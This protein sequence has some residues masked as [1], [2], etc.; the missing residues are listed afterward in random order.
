M[1]LRRQESCSGYPR[2][3]YLGRVQR[4]ILVSRAGTF[5]VVLLGKRIWQCHLSDEAVRSVFS[6]E[7]RR[8]FAASLNSIRQCIAL[9]ADGNAVWSICHP[10][11]P[12]L[13]VAESLQSTDAIKVWKNEFPKDKCPVHLLVADNTLG[14]FC[15][16]GTNE[17]ALVIRYLND[18]FSADIAFRE[19]TVSLPDS[20]SPSG[21]DVRARGST[22]HAIWR[23]SWY[24][25][26][27]ANLSTRH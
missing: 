20:S 24:S 13:R 5:W 15:N 25:L 17:S 21:W 6:E 7:M 2:F 10:E 1:P 4:S 14:F 26:D 3:P 27:V 11:W 9:N 18:R 23:N 22:L 12:I 8:T 16:V 19:F